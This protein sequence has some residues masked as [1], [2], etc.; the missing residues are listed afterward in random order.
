MTKM[1][2]SPIFWVADMQDNNSFGCKIYSESIFWGL[3]FTL[4]THTPVYEY[5]K[6]PP[7]ASLI[8]TR[9]RAETPRSIREHAFEN[10][11]DLDVLKFLGTNETN[12]YTMNN[13]Y[14][15]KSRQKVRVLELH[16]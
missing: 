8:H 2:L 4:H 6:Y 3:N 9:T 11:G 13:N 5:S 12:G 16:I 15:L 7:G 10:L 1:K 14:L